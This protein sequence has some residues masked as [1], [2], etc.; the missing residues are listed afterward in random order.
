[1]DKID[2]F[3]DFANS[4]SVGASF[5]KLKTL[6]IQIPVYTLVIPW[7]TVLT[8]SVSMPVETDPPGLVDFLSEK[9]LLYFY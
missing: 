6:W 2:T 1:M 8:A 5:H 7:S 9:W 4:T 3:I